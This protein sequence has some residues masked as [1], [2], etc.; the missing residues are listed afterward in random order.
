MFFVVISDYQQATRAFLILAIIS[1]FVA[2]IL[3]VAYYI[4]HEM[5]A[6]YIGINH[7]ITSKIIITGYKC[8]KAHESHYNSLG[9]PVNVLFRGI[10]GICR[11]ICAN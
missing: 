11:G 8:C 5:R 1:S 7:V 2:M 6:G 10:R 3:S 9:N 4:R